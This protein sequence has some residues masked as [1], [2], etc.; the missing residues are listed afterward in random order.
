MRRRVAE[1]GATS[2]AASMADAFMQLS[3]EKLCAARLGE[4]AFTGSGG[5]VGDWEV[6]THCVRDA[7]DCFLDESVDSEMRRGWHRRARTTLAARAF[8]A[9]TRLPCSSQRRRVRRVHLGGYES[10]LE[11]L[12]GLDPGGEV[13]EVTLMA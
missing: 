7:A 9:W 10:D 4:Q 3:S 13:A 5:P 1:E 6:Q 11:D 12:P 8:R 2:G